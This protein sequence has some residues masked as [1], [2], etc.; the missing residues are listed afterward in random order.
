MAKL[1]N[2]I[3]TNNNIK[4]VFDLGLFLYFILNQLHYIFAF[5]GVMQL[6]V[7]GLINVIGIIMFI[8]V[9]YKKMDIKVLIVLLLLILFGMISFIIIGNFNIITYITIIRYFGVM[10]YLLYYKQN[11]KMMTIIMYIT[12]I[13]FVPVLF[14]RLGYNMFSKSS[15]NY[16]SIILL[17]ANFVYNKSFWDLKRKAPIFPT[18]ASLF[19]CIFA[20][21]RG[22]IIAYI[23]FLSGTIIK[24]FVHLK[25]NPKSK[26]LDNLSD[27]KEIPTITDEDINNNRIKRKF[28][29]LKKLNKLNIYK[30]EIIIIFLIILIFSS[31]F[32]LKY[33]NKKYKLFKFNKSNLSEILKDNVTDS[34]YGF[35]GK[36]LKSN[37]RVEMI[38]KYINYMFSN[39]KYFVFGVK[40]DIESIFVKYN[41]NLHNSY[42]GLHSK[43][44]IGGIIVCGYLGF[45]ALFVIIKR[46]EWGHLLI[47]LSIL[48]RVFVDTAAFPG[49]LD[50]ILFY[51]FFGFYYIDFK[52]TNNNKIK[53]YLNR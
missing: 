9:M 4:K 20:G 38:K 29:F 42:L 45:R 8:V 34:S 40:L 37:T 33:L 50:I 48:V 5:T 26:I 28:L 1:K 23:L 18:I 11:P 16:Y 30:R 7:I 44:G 21:G 12:L 10:I 3:L 19:I 35:E 14:Q 15:R 47:Y 36:G 13:L 43:L 25:D 24:N 49:Q 27:T 51:Y 6:L 17:M 46:K 52:K 41:F 31:I 39:F 53:K 2:K 32:T 22:G